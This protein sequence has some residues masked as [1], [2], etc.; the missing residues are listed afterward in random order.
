MACRRSVLAAL[1]ALCAA[2]LA[3][4][5]PDAGMCTAPPAAAATAL[6]TTVF[7]ADMSWYEYAK[8]VKVCC[9]GFCVASSLTARSLQAGVTVILPVGSTEQARVVHCRVFA[10]LG[11]VRLKLTPATARPSPSLERG[12]RHPHRRVQARGRA[13]WRHRRA[14]AQLRLQERAVHG[15]R[16]VHRHCWPGRFDAGGAA[17]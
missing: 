2:L 7:M 1:A 10:L 5:E 15:R 3:V 11:C 6:N 9:V 17:A 4:A 14:D 16:A 8:R 12:R 13:D